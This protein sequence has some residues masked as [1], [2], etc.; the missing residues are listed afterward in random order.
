MPVPGP[1]YW[2]IVVPVAVGVVPVPELA[3]GAVVVCACAL[4]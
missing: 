1:R 2:L 4:V 3:D